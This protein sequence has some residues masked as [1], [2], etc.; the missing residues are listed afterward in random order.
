M[1]KLFLATAIC[2]LAINVQAQS[3]KNVFFV[4]NSYTSYN[5]LPQLVA[6][7]ALTTNDTLIHSAHTPGGNTFFQ[8]AANSNVL[9]NLRLG[10]WDYVVLQEQSQMPAF[11]QPQVENEV[12]PAAKR[13]V[14]SMRLA[15]PCTVPIFYMTWGRKNGD[16]SLCNQ[17]LTNA[18]TYE[19]MDSMIALRYTNMAQMNDALLSPVGKVWRAIRTQYPSYELYIADESHP[20]FLGSMAAAYTFYT[21]IFQKDPTLT[22]Y[23]SSLDDTQEE[24][25][26]NIVK[27]VVFNELENWYVGINDNPANFTINT[28][29]EGNIELTNTSG[30]ATSFEWN[31]GDGNTSTD[32]NPVHTFTTNGTYEITLTTQPCNKTIM[33]TLVIDNITETPVVA[34]ENLANKA[35]KV[36]P[37][38]TQNIINIQDLKALESF[39]LYNIAGA[40]I[41]VNA[42]YNTTEMQVDLSDLPTGIYFLNLIEKENT[43]SIRIMKY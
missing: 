28:L 5:N 16:A 13:M 39:V 17:G 38:P 8:H 37:N 30:Y 35:I 2:A 21:I 42:S 15:N 25:I 22:N 23:N 36:F 32:E 19:K 9:S 31:F 11:P 3:K 14:D 27:N 26:K 6:N 33:Q 29:A 12:Y 18:C 41:P 1:K 20:S 7:I 4:G 43:T 34:I 40:I 10:T 24:N